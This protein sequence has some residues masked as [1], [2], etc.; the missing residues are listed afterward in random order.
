MG[1]LLRSLLRGLLRADRNH[2]RRVARG[3]SRLAAHLEARCG[4]VAARPG[5]CAGHC[6]GRR[7]GVRS[8]P[9][10]HV[11]RVA[12]QRAWSVHPD[13]GRDRADR[14]AGVR[15]PAAGHC[16]ARTAL[17]AVAAH[18]RG[19]RIRGRHRALARALWRVAADLQRHLGIAADL[20]AQQPARG[21]PAGLRHTQ[22]VASDHGVALRPTP[23]RGADDVR[24]VHRE[25]E[26]RRAGGHRRRAVARGP[27]REGL[28]RLHGDLHRAG[29][30]TLRA[31]GRPQHTRARPVGAAALRAG[32]QH[33]PH[34][35]T[36]RDRGRPGSQCA[37]RAGPG[38]PR[39]TLP[40]QTACA[41]RGG[42]GAGGLRAVARATAAVFRQR[43][44][45]LRRGAR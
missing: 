7:P 37:L 21:R 36:L 13:P 26:S 31:R 43:V 28:G 2:L 6:A 11:A 24:R 27:A 19:R 23:T 39:A 25:H 16:R 41:A 34:A 12:D 8:W 18:G 10:R 4:H 44:A 15:L 20:L 45:G 32:L 3:A 5:D 42:G 1:R 35:A 17:A 9:S 29:P 38:P 14:G 30:R 40:A 33:D 22:S